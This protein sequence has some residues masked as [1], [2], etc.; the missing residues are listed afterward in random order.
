[1]LKS[2][3][4]TP[5]E[6]KKS[7]NN[8]ARNKVRTPSGT[9]L[10]SSVKDIRDFFSKEHEQSYKG[11]KRSKKV[12]TSDSQFNSQFDSQASLFREPSAVKHRRC[13][14]LDKHLRYSWNNNKGASASA[15]VKAR[16]GPKQT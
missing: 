10:S 13:F 14:K 9:P 15:K 3:N 11:N 8:D 5:K 12:L 1:M 7:S 4:K 6:G 16:H 2:G